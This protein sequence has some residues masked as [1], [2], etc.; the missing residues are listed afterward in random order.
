MDQLLFGLR[1]LHVA[2]EVV[3]HLE[4]DQA[5]HQFLATRVIDG[6]SPFLRIEDQHD[7]RVD[8]VGFVGNEVSD[9]ALHAGITLVQVELEFV[10]L[11]ALVVLHIEEHTDQIRL[12]SLDFIAE[13]EGLR[14]IDPFDVRVDRPLAKFWIQDVEA[15]VSLQETV[16]EVV[17]AGAGELGRGEGPRGPGGAQEGA[18]RG[19]RQDRERH[20][21]RARR[22]GGV[23]SLLRRSASEARRSAST[24][25]CSH[26]RERHWPRQVHN[27]TPLCSNRPSRRRN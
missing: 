11:L 1:Q 9:L 5:L 25:H 8:C 12:E 23:R 20:S 24:H 26:D 27:G 22:E 2:F 16:D 21:I 15:D 4:V 10:E 7:V 14:G 6:V 13:E 18:A 3:P 19:D 17:A